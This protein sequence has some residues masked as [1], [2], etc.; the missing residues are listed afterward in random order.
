MGFTIRTVCREYSSLINKGAKGDTMIELNL[1]I[2]KDGK[3]V[4]KSYKIK[5]KLLL[6]D[7]NQTNSSVRKN[8]GKLELKHWNPDLGQ[9]RKGCMYADELNILIKDTE[10]EYTQVGLSWETVKRDFTSGELINYQKAAA[11][12]AMGF[13]F[14]CPYA[15]P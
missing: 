13:C 6:K 14:F 15:L 7:W 12:K 3:T 1:A 11:S 8:K 5:G 10:V 9:V 2:C 4:F